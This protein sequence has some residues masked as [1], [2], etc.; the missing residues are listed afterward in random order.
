M[1]KFLCSTIWAVSMVSVLLLVG[2]KKVDAYGFELVH[3]V[4]LDIHGYA[5]EDF[6]YSTKNN[7]M[8][9][10]GGTFEHNSASL[11][12]TASV[13]DTTQFW[14]RLHHDKDSE[15]TIDWFYVDQ[16]IGNYFD[17][18]A[19]QF[20][21][22]L[23]IYNFYAENKFLQ[24]TQ[25]EPMMY[26]PDVDHMIFENIAGV[27]VEYKGETIGA[28]IFGGGHKLENGGHAKNVIGLRIPYK[29]PLEGLTLIASGAMFTGKS[30]DSSGLEISQREKLIVGSA[31]YENHGLDLKAEI[32]EKMMGETADMAKMNVLSYYVQGGYLIADRWTPYARYDVLYGDTHKKSDPSFY[33]KDA[34]VGLSYLI[35]SFLKVK[36]EEHFIRGYNVPVQSGEVAAGA[37][38]KDWMMFVAG[39]DFVF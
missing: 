31:D 19:G 39:V 7:W 27:D 13:L 26:S 38:A 10:K 18:R 34:T 32:A 29:T 11:I 14:V 5:N 4:N 16:K 37:G 15:A 3:G 2:A 25:L 17:V 8:D 20:K 6:L 12:F 36:A 33:Q 22:P 21:Y 28:E 23:G 9:A 35:N 1:K 24:L 30:T